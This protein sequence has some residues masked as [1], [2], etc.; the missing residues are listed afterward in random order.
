M[1]ALY[2]GYAE[3]ELFLLQQGSLHVVCEVVHRATFRGSDVSSERRHC[4]GGSSSCL[5]NI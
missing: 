4:V 2:S 5:L 3:E 1:K